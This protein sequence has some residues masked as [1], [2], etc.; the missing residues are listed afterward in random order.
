V[1]VWQVRISLTVHA[2][3][4]DFMMLGSLTGSSKLQLVTE[5]FHVNGRFALQCI[6]MMG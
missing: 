2:I 1:Y 3:P 4:T 5:G 6:V